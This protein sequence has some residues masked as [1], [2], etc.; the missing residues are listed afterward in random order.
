MF[1]AAG[2]IKNEE[3]TQ[4]I[5]VEYCRVL[6]ERLTA[7]AKQRIALEADEA[8]DLVYAEEAGLWRHFGYVSMLECWSTWNAR[9]IMGRTPRRSGC[10]SPASCS[11]CRS[12]SCER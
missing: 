8:R 12:L 4:A 10:A 1:S 9:C 2:A 3:T 5:R 11:S 7:R 6:H